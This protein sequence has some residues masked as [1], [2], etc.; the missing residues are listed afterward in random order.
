MNDSIYDIYNFTLSDLSQNQMQNLK[1]KMSATNPKL[2]GYIVENI[3]YHLNDGIPPT[4]DIPREQERIT[5]SGVLLYLQ[6][7]YPNIRISYLITISRIYLCH[8]F[9]SYLQYLMW[10]LANDKDI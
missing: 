3:E 6:Q 10:Q 9:A 8:D 2:P 5:P 4:D 1:L 7:V